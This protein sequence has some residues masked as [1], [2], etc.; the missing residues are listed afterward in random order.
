MFISR[1]LLIIQRIGGPQTRRQRFSQRRQRRVQ[2]VRLDGLALDVQRGAAHRRPR[3]S[4]HYARRRDLVQPVGE[5]DPLAD[6]LL[7]V[8]R[9]DREVRRV[10]LRLAHRR[11]T[12]RHLPVDLLDALLP[13]TPF[14]R[15]HFQVPNAR[16]A[17]VPADQ[18]L[19]R[20]VGDRKR[21][22]RR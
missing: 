21:F 5:E 13:I 7:Q 6:V 17:A 18:T 19:Q 16:F 3:Q 12:H 8:L 10:D 11:Q 22:R 1:L 20:V 2:G 15:F 4:H 9:V 14:P